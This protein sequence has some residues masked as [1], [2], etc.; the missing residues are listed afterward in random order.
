MLTR[1]TKTAYYP[2]LVHRLTDSIHA[3]FR[4]CLT[5]SP[6]AS[7][8]LL[9]HLDEQGTHTPKQINMP[10]THNKAAALEAQPH[11]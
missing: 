11:C 7:L 2:I 4:R 5:T 10:G 1:P 9:L 8:V 3:S 6:C